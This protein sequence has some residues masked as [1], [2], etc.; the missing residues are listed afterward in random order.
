MSMTPIRLISLK[1]YEE[2]EKGEERE[3]GRDGGEK[4]KDFEHIVLMNKSMGKRTCSYV[5]YMEINV[6][7]NS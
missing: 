3:R 5:K 1:E 7:I 4:E 6:L 2:G